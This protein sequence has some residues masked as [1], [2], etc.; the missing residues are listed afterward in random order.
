MTGVVSDVRTG[1]P[2]AVEDASIPAPPP[3][4]DAAR[5]TVLVWETGGHR[6][7]AE[8]PENRKE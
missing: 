7:R 2:S 5:A 3:A 8:R 4:P 6:P 1:R